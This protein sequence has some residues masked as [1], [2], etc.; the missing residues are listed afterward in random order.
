MCIR[1][2]YLCKETRHGRSHIQLTLCFNRRT[3]SLTVVE[4][5][6]SFFNSVEL[7]RI[8][9]G[10]QVCLLLFRLVLR[11][12]TDLDTRK[13]VVIVNLYSLTTSLCSFLSGGGNRCGTYWCSLYDGTNCVCYSSHYVLETIGSRYTGCNGWF[14]RWRWRRQRR[15][16]W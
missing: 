11:R 8:F 4:H 5:F 7:T 10:I 16:W 14:W 12:K 3:T 9:N 15:R 2:K 6:H 1:I 13:F